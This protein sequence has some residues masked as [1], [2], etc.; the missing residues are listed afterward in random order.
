MPAS[1]VLTATILFDHVV[2]PRTLFGIGAVLPLLHMSVGVARWKHVVIAAAFRTADLV[3]LI[4]GKLARP[5]CTPCSIASRPWAQRDRRIN[6]I[7]MI[8]KLLELSSRH[9]CAN[10]LATDD[11]AALW[12]GTDHLA[13]TI[14]ARVDVAVDE[15]YQTLAAKVMP[16]A[17][18]SLAFEH[19]KAYAA[20]VRFAGGISGGLV[21]RRSVVVS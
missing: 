16:A 19:I 20:S 11:L 3:T 2:A 18:R 21:R 14:F 7:V 1:H 4:A 15:A 8:V 6:R 5:S 9:H 13:H 17:Q 10:Q 12:L